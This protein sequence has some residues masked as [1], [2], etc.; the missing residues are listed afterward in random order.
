MFYGKG[1]LKQDNL[2]IFNK[3]IRKKA[4]LDAL[5]FIGD[6]LLK[7]KLFLNEDLLQLFSVLR[8]AKSLLFINLSDITNP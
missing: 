7:A 1:K 8:V 2:Y 6:D 5:I 4:F 3:I